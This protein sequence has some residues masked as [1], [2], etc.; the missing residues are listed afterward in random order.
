MPFGKYKGQPL[1]QVPLS[2]LLWLYESKKYSRDLRIYIEENLEALV[3]R[4]LR[5]ENNNI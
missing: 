1:E 5:K 3:K 2:Y 4:L